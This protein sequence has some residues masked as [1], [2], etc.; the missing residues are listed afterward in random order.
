MQLASLLLELVASLM[1]LVCFFFCRVLAYYRLLN[2]KF[3]YLTL[4]CE[5]LKSNDLANIVEEPAT[6]E[7]LQPQS[8]FLS[9]QAIKIVKLESLFSSYEHMFNSSFSGTKFSFA[10]VGST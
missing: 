1:T 8:Y 7:S 5:N 6:Y 3:P 2:H 4:L 9:F 10:F